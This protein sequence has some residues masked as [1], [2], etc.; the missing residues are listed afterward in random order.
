MQRKARG[1]SLPR[2]EG[3]EE[4]GLLL[5]LVALVLAVG[6][7]NPRFLTL[8]SVVTVLRQATFLGFMAFGVV[9]LMSMGELDL[10]IGGLYALGATT[11]ALLVQGGVSPYAAAVVA[12]CVGAALGGLNGVLANLLQIPIIIISLGTLSVYRGVNL[13]LS[14]GRPLAG[15]PREH[16]LFRLLGGEIGRI[17]TILFLFA[18]V[19]L[20]LD[21]VY[22]RSR[23]GATVRAIGSNRDA[24]E[25]VGLRVAAV[26]TVTT[27][28][29]GGLCGLAGIATLA[30]FRSADPSLGIG[31]ELTVIAAVIIGG[32]SLA[33]GVGTLVGALIG[34]LIIAVISNGLV[35]FG[36]SANWTQ[37]LTGLVI[38]AA[39]ALDRILKRRSPPTT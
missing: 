29:L 13:V 12:V 11:M 36:V 7:P 30:F 19:G 25:Y 2:F 20:L 17:P 27:A 32:T 38:L 31:V 34:V 28:L 9:Y 39:V 26:R 37:L 24:A 16:P 3:F 35:F 23:F 21:V 1:V 33:G 14:G 8:D 4:A 15:M 18:T 6:I 5:V 22:R 10:S